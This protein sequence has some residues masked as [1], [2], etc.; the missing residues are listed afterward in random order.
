MS[1][2]HEP[3]KDRDFTVFTAVFPAL[4]ATAM[5]GSKWAFCERCLGCVPGTRVWT[6]RVDPSKVP[7][8]GGRCQI[9]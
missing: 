1:L 6:N 3:H 8:S 9:I 2:E 7:G 4:K 5:N